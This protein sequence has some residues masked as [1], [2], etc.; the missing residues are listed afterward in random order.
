ML[1]RSYRLAL[2][3][4]VAILYLSGL[5]RI[6]IYGPDE[7][8]YAAIGEEMARSGDWVTPRLWGTPWYEKSPLLYWLTAA[9]R[10]CGFGKE[11]GP[12]L[13]VALIACGFV[14]WM[15][16][17]LKPRLG[18]PVATNASI[19]LAS[20]A[21]WIAIGAVSVTDVPLSAAMAVCVLLIV[22]DGG[23]AWVAGAFLGLAVLAKGLLPFVLFAPLLWWLWKQGQL[24]KMIP[25]S[26]ACVMVAAP[27]YG[28]MWIRYGMPFFVEFIVKHHILRFFSDSLQ[29]VRPWWFYFPIGFGLLV[30]WSLIAP[31][32]LIKRQADLR[33][34]FLSYWM[35][36]SFVFF[37]G[38]K[39]KLPGYILPLLPIFCILLANSL[40][41]AKPWVLAITALLVTVLGLR[42]LPELPRLLAEGGNRTI[43]GSSFEWWQAAAGI[44]AGLCCYWIAAQRRATAAL[45]FVAGLVAAG[46][47]WVKLGGIA[48][49]I[50]RL[51]TSRPV[52]L[53]APRDGC[54]HPGDRN[55]RYG[56]SYYW[57][58][59]VPICNDM[60]IQKRIVNKR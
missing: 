14:V 43:S 31:Y 52:S 23:P 4:A 18:C 37:S 15:Y 34:R 26:V 36:F 1:T 29:H 51:A 38:S 42:F 25:I 11:V 17:F 45:T 60:S 28:A 32:A 44:V 59:E 35:L 22:F 39:N 3:A 19:L 56:L 21:G 47:L 41:W 48:E 55:L 50:D 10:V 57:G 53:T 24:R 6:G 58:F 16:C 20:C 49:E 5:G 8:R 33:L 46:A 9:A 2:F 54:V 7:P 27:W 13:P 40:E 30:P 12:R